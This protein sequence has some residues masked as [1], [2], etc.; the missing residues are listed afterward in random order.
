MAVKFSLMDL[1]LTKPPNGPG[2][3]VHRTRPGQW[4]LPMH[5]QKMDSLFLICVIKA[6]CR[7]WKG[8]CMRWLSAVVPD[9][10]HL[11]PS[12]VTESLLLWRRGMVPQHSIFAP[13]SR[14][15][16]RIGGTCRD[17]FLLL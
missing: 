12:A 10:R 11:L 5:V 6:H 8:I 3:S 17:S 14:C 1:S 9:S 13:P 4:I 2:R 7:F 15:V 16:T